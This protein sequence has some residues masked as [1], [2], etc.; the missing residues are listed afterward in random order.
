VRRRDGES[1]I[2]PR[3]FRFPLPVLSPLANAAAPTSA[4]RFITTKPARAKCSTSRFA[5][6]SAMISSAFVDPLAALE[7]QREGVGEVR[8]V[9]GREAFGA[10]GIP[11][12]SGK[13]RT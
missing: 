5:T 10:P 6:I 11:D 1:G 9:G 4:G 8:G 2:A 3:P 12:D 13:V 7:A